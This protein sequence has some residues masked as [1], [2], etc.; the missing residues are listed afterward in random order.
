M[1]QVCL[2][3]HLNIQ[4]GPGAAGPRGATGDSGDDGVD[5]VPGIPGAPGIDGDGGILGPKGFAGAKV[6]M[7][8]LAIQNTYTYMYMCMYL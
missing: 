3:V 2:Y 7:C 4:G 8:T 5:G 1:L 6:R